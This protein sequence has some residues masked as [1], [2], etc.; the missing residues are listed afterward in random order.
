M[1]Y[2]IGWV[3][4]FIDTGIQRWTSWTQAHSITAFLPQRRLHPNANCPHCLGWPPVATNY[5]HPLWEVMEH[6][7]KKYQANISIDLIDLNYIICLF[8]NIARK[9]TLA[10]MKMSWSKM[11]DCDLLIMSPSYNRSLNNTRILLR[12]S[13]GIM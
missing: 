2:E 1:L 6:I 4:G 3:I 12:R 8:L 9:I 7:S 10:W 13:R 11:R 5:V